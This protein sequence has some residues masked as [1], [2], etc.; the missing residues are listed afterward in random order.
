M[1]AKPAALFLLLLVCCGGSAQEWR[2]YGGNPDSL[3]F[4]K[5]TVEMLEH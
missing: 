1:A 3:L 5:S 2:V 4:T